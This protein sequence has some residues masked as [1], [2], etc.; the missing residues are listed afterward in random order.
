ML[1]RS[2]S[3]RGRRLTFTG[4]VCDWLGCIYDASQAK[5]WNERGTT[6]GALCLNPWTLSLHCKQVLAR[7]L[8]VESQAGSDAERGR[9]GK[10]K[11][12]GFAENVISRLGGARRIP[13]ASLTLSR[14][15]RSQSEI[16]ISGQD[17]LF[18]RVFL[19]EHFSVRGQSKCCGSHW[20]TG[21][22]HSESEDPS[23]CRTEVCY[24]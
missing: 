24:L 19:V 9:K 6:P 17:S 4:P 12:E 18:W 2:T 20:T 5:Y 11:R 10:G 23:S 3:V 7:Y 21:S 16:E 15:C 1:L 8:A 14:L 13:A 22:F